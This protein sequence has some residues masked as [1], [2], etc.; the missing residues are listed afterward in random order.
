MLTISLFYKNYGR[1]QEWSNVS[2]KILAISCSMCV[3]KNKSKWHEYVGP[4]FQ[5]ITTDQGCEYLNVDVRKGGSEGI[6]RS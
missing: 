6:G 2:G 3:E 1:V 5:W 4:S